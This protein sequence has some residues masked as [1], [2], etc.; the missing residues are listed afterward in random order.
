MLQRIQTVYLF[1]ATACLLLPFFFSIAKFDLGSA[2]Y[3]FTATGLMKGGENLVA[4]PFQWIFLGLAGYTAAA[5]FMYGN[6]Q[7][8]MRMGRMNYLLLTALII[9]LYFVTDGLP[10]KFEVPAAVIVS[11]GVGFF[12]PVAALAFVFLANRAIRSD[13]NIIRSIDRLR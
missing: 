12:M 6:R 4:V 11:Y 10:Q 1:L 7:L 2:S 5:I 9:T 13:E 8:Q 3:L